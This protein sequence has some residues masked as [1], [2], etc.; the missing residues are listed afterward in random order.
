MSKNYLF[1]HGYKGNPATP[2]WL[3]WAAHELEKQSDVVTMVPQMPYPD[4]PVLDAW[5]SVISHAVPLL[6]FP[7]TVFIGHSLGGAAILHAL[8]ESDVIAEHVILVATPINSLNKAPLQPFYESQWDFENLKTKANRFTCMY[9]KDDP[10]V[11][12]EH[13]QQFAEKL[14]GHL[15]SFNDKGHFES[16]E[17]PELIFNLLL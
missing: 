15:I 8:E 13:G 3:L 11:P 4:T 5:L 9:S 14:G 1:I 2:G 16:A 17:F 12:F 6:Y 10:L 7:E